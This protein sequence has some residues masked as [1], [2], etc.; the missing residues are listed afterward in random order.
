MTRTMYNGPKQTLVRIPEWWV[1]KHRI[2][3]IVNENPD[4]SLSDLQLAW[5]PRFLTHAFEQFDKSKSI[6]R[7]NTQKILSKCF[8]GLLQ[9]MNYNPDIFGHEQ[10]I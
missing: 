10:T 2:N 6:D 7:D 9:D 8:W 5:S 1:Y 3:E 4:I